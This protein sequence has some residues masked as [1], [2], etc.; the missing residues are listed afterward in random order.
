M[1]YEVYPEDEEEGEEFN[2]EA[3]FSCKHCPAIG[4]QCDECDGFGT[5]DGMEPDEDSENCPKCNGEGVL[6]LKQPASGE[7]E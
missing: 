2:A 1:L 7:G 4:I 5:L 3:E 6:E